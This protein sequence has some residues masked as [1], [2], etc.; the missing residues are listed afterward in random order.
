MKLLFSLILVLQAALSTAQ[1]QAELAALLAKEKV[2][3]MQL[4][5]TA[6]NQAVTVYN[7]GQRNNNLP[8]AIDAGTTFQAA[9]LGK[10]V[11]AYIALR[12]HDRGLLDLNQPLLRYYRDPR[13]QAQP[14]AAAITARMV[15]A[16]SSGLPNWAENPL[17]PSWKTSELTLKYAPDSCWNYSG[18]G[19]VL[20]QKVLE[21]LTAKPLETLAQEEVFGPLRM[22]GSSYVWRPSFGKNACF[23]HDAAGKPTEVRRFKEANAGFS[24][25]TNATD[26]SRFVQAL[27]KGQGL[28]PA[29]AQ[30]FTAPANEAQRCGKA[31]SATDPYV[32][33]ACGVGLATTSRGPALWHWGDNGDFQGFF[34]A[35]PE[36][37]ESLVFF[38]NSANGLRL[39]DAV[40]QLFF[41]P[42]QYRA[43]QWLAEEK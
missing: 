35:F 28:Q 30:L 24:L 20:L 27:L 23:G 33:W 25:L 9:S 32:A 26:Y 22:P 39:T 31:V 21:Q 14:R 6:R 40:L 2:P 34:I 42:G 5:Y 4:V 11:L 29:T 37:Q 3:G 38:T 43:M 41:E 10:V 12:L 15:L 13:L 19:F 18:E 16:H 1:H 36:T 7:V 17:N 8:Q